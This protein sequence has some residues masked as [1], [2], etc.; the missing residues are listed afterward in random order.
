MQTA[1]ATSAQATS[2]QALRAQVA[3]YKE[4]NPK[5]RM[6]DIAEGL[7]VSEA[8]LVALGCG[9]TAIRLKG[10]WTELL[11]EIPTLGNVMALTRNEN[12]VIEKVGTYNPPTFMAHAG[13]GQVVGDDIDLRLFMNNWAHGF[14]VTSE[15]R[16]KEQKSLQFFGKDGVAVHKIFLKDNSNR[17]AYDALVAKYTA[18]DQSPEQAVQPADPKK[19]DL[20]DSEIDAAGF[21][22][23]WREMKDT[24]DFFMMCRK[25]T[26]GRKQALRLAEGEFAWQVPVGSF[27]QALESA[28]ASQTPI[29]VF[30][31]N[32]G[33]IEIHTGP[34]NKL[35]ALDNWYN[36][37]DPDFN[38]HVREDRIDSAYIVKKP[39]VD[40]VVTSLE[41]FDAQGENIL[42]MFGKRKPGLPEIEAWRS[43]VGQLAPLAS[44]Y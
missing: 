2:A 13:V 5:A 3:A 31:G 16:G 36:V 32:P 11:S 20:P 38:L 24:H 37:M 21:M 43:I 29:M 23:A 18:E 1:Q 44:V 19:P 41:V 42:L 40:G 10:P 8:Q 33:C 6:F 14:A 9:S 4:A 30:V 28:Q 12:A 15:V 26:V 22:Q 35:L 34:V 39:T 25:Y 27:R 7:G 17:D